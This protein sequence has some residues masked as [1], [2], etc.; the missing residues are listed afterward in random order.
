MTAFLISSLTVLYGKA[1]ITA[2]FTCSVLFNIF[3]SFSGF[4]IMLWLAGL[5]NGDVFVVG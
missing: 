4:D 3:F 5:S 1:A 2:C